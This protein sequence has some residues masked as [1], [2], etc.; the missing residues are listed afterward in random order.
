M[1]RRRARRR[2]ALIA[3][4]CLLPACA[5]APPPPQRSTP[6][7]RASAATPATW[8]RRD[9]LDLALQ[10]Y[11]CGRAQGY[12]HQP[13]LTVIDYSLPSSERRLWVIDLQRRR[14]LFNE[15]VAHGLNSGDERAYSFSN[16]EGSKQSSL[17]LFRTDET[18]F[19]RHGYSLRLSGLEPG[20]NDLARERAIVIHGA[21]YVSRAHVAVWGGVGRSWGCPALDQ[22]VSPRV[23]D[24]I[25]GGSAV[26][27]YYPDRDWLSTSPFLH[28]GRYARSEDR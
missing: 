13:T 25:Q 5:T 18:Y 22:A 3:L 27:A 28:C 2:L 1:E 7:R 8:P 4:A 6:L 15:L 19:G 12:F 16:R 14:V 26:F 24:R 20:V 9:V 11:Q 17:G 10:A 21:P 23:I